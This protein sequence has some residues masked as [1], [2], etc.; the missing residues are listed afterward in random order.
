LNLNSLPFV[1]TVLGP[2]LEIESIQ[3]DPSV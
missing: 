2:D 1:F 3:K